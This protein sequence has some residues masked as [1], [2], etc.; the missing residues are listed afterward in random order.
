MRPV[1]NWFVA[2]RLAMTAKLERTCAARTVRL[3]PTVVP[4]VEGKAEDKFLL[5]CGT[6]SLRVR[7]GGKNNRSVVHPL[8]DRFC[9][10][11]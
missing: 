4:A 10:E 8:G 5:Q 1:L 6:Q 2:L 7:G 3:I 9:T 11:S